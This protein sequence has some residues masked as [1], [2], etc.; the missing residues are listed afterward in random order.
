MYQSRQTS[1]LGR[2]LLK[3]GLISRIQLQQALTHQI[4]HQLKLGE[5]LVA[6]GFIQSRTIK[7]VLSK[8][9]LM[10]SIIAGVM[11]AS[12]P[13]TSVMANESTDSFSFSKSTNYQSRDNQLI[14]EQQFN[15]RQ[16]ADFTLGIKY[17][18]SD[19]SGI[20][21][22][23]GNATPNTIILSGMYQ[24]ALVPQI[25]IFT[26]QHKNTAKNN[27]FS[28]DDK[29]PRFDRYKNTIP[30]IYNLTLK[31]YSIFEQSDSKSKV[32]QLNKVKDLNNRNFELMFSVSKHF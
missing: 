29:T 7:R 19:H 18:I 28:R 15:Y 25:S 21:F 1:R 2:L 27:L 9:R 20:V 16:A 12:S 26:S 24:D 17:K 31:G 6:L 30:V 13:F 32:F 4:A 23:L 5:S 22:G 3:E 10:R 11:F 14:D 8:Q